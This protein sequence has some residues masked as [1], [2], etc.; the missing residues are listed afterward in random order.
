MLS[1]HPK[2]DNSVRDWPTPPEKARRRFPGTIDVLLAASHNDS[3][4]ERCNAGSD[5]CQVPVGQ[6]K[7]QPA[8]QGNALVVVSDERWLDRPLKALK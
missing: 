3:D 4:G 5:P 7:C 6:P 8:I 1:F 2:D